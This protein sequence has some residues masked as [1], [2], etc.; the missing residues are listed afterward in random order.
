MELLG[1][2]HKDFYPLLQFM[3]MVDEGDINEF[4]GYGELVYINDRGDLL[5]DKESN[6]IN[7]ICDYTSPAY[8]NKYNLY[9]VG[10]VWYNK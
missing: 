7:D 10:A 6:A 8:E 5:I 1:S 9:L 2:A 4:D 3:K